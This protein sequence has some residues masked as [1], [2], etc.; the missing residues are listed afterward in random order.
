[1]QRALQAIRDGTLDGEGIYPVTYLVSPTLRLLA[2]PAW[3][4]DWATRYPQ[5]G[6]AAE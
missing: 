6:P 3:L 1:L 5:Y 2:E 4:K